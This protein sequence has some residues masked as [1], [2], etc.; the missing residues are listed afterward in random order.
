MSTLFAPL[1]LY[2]LRIN[3]RIRK[4]SF[5]K[6][7]NEADYAII[8][9]AYR[10]LDMVPDAVRSIL[11][12]RYDNFLIYVVA[13]NCAGQNLGFEDERLIVLHP[14]KVLASNIRSHLYATQHFIRDHDRLTIIDSDNVVH[15]DYL[16]SL[17]QLFDRGFKAVQGVRAA[18]NLDTN[19]ACLDE[20][21]DMLYR[22]IDRKLLFEAGSSST[23]AGSGMAFQTDLYRSLLESNELDGAGFDK[24][25]QSKLVEQGHRIAFS[26]KAIVY[27]AKTSA[28]EQLVKQRARWINAWGRFAILGVR[29]LVKGIITFNRNRVLFA[30]TMLRPPL[31]ILAAISG[32]S[33]IV[34]LWVAPWLSLLWFLAAISFVGSFLLALSYF[35]ADPRIYRALKSI[36]LFIYY[37]VKALFNARK[38]NKL[39]VAT[40]H[41]KVETIANDK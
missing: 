23:L 40:E 16:I 14:E 36:H 3:R 39:S 11:R 8:V 18:R 10:Q 4:K 30:I 2:I 20:A 25:F 15:P 13:D 41:T 17:N 26:E 34:N 19:Y 37:Q 12:M 6:P 7:V 31:F 33:F 22:F 38:A 29:I 24:L 27:D 35:A 9:T 28:P 5:D 21:G 1:F 32:V